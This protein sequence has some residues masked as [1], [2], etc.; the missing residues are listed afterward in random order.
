MRDLEALRIR[1]IRDP[2]A[3]VSRKPGLDPLMTLI[4]PRY[5]PRRPRLRE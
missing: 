4:P 2:G 1:R 3:G 5:R